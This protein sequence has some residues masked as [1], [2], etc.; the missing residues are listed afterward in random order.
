MSALT[1]IPSIN[2]TLASSSG[3]AGAGAGTTIVSVGDP[4][5][6]SISNLGQI[7]QTLTQGS[8]VTGAVNFS[9][10]PM[11]QSLLNPGSIS[12]GDAATQ[13]VP[14]TGQTN[15][16]NILLLLA[17]SVAAIWISKKL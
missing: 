11:F 12:D 15:W 6:S 10:S 14:P 1:P 5:I 7:L 16:S 4:S 3:V 2:P 17:I 9:N 13:I 8:N